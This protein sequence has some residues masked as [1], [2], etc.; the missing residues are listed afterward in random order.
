MDINIGAFSWSPITMLSVSINLGPVIGALLSLSLGAWA[1]WQG[2]RILRHGEKL[3]NPLAHLALWMIKTVRG[4]EAA[5][6]RYMQL[7]TSRKMRID[8]ISAVIAGGLLIVGGILQ[9]MGI[10]LAYFVKGW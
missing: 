5:S 7:T 8:G 9:S 3:L 2:C 4:E 1:L 10:V 6:R